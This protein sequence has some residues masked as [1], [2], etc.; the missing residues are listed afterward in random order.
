[1]TFRRLVRAHRNEKG[2]TLV[3]LVMAMGVTAIILGG[4]TA[5]LW[6]VFNTNTRSVNHMTAVRQVQSAGYW[7][8]QDA[9]MAQSITTD[10]GTTSHLPM[11]LTWTDWDGVVHSVTYSFDNNRLKRTQGSGGDLIAH[12]IVPK[13]PT[14]LDGTI[15]DFT[16]GK[17]VFTVKATVGSGATAGTEVR[18][19]EVT[20][21]TGG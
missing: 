15:C 4:I 20:P 8:S 14:D 11:T 12:Y 7:V 9:L 17:L 10:N 3:E 18:V 6:Q 21:R 1:M 16:S 13:S 2:L 5:T 19:Y